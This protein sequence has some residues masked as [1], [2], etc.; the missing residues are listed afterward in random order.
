[1]GVSHDRVSLEMEEYA[2]VHSLKKYLVILFIE[3][4][5]GKFIICVEAV[6]LVIYSVLL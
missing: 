6:V 2:T 4:I 3:E 5:K 1:M